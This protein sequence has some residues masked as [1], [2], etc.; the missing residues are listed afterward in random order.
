MAAIDEAFGPY[1]LFGQLNDAEVGEALLAKRMGPRGFAKRVVIRRVR[2][3]AGRRDDRF[4]AMVSEA[5]AAALLSHANIA[6]LL[7]LGAR[8]P[9]SFVATEHV[10]GCTLADCLRSRQPLPWAIAAH[11]VNEAARGLA[12]V[13]RRRRRNGELLQLVHRRITSRRIAL[14]TAGDVK[15]TGFGTSWAWV[16]RGAYRAPEARRNEPVDGRADVFA[17][18]VALRA[19]LSSEDSPVPVRRAIEQATHD[20]QEHRMTAAQLHQAL[21]EA[22]HASAYGVCSRDIARLVN[23]RAQSAALPR[24]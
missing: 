12:Y 11:I 24:A 13:H 14:S 2:W 4:A 5:N 9:W 18:G 3:P 6:H 21:S 7:D 22:L 20:F 17:L 16:E 8:G 10:D 19:S 1:R 23:D 15:I